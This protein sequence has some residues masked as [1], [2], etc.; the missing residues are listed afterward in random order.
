LDSFHNFHRVCA[1]LEAIL[2]DPGRDRDR[3]CNRADLAQ[4]AY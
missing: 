1:E 2:P 3:K 4:Q